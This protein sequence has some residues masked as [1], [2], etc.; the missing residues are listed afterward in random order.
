MSSKMP[1]I[2]QVSFVSVIIQ[3]L[4]LLLMTLGFYQIDKT[5]FLFYSFGVFVVLLVIVRYVIPR[6][7]RQGITLYKMQKFEQ[8]IPFFDK[9][10]QFFK[11]YP[12]IDKYRYFVLLS[13]SRVCYTEMA[14]LNKAFC[15]AQAGKK[16]ESITEYKKVLT[17]FP[18][19]ESAKTALKMLE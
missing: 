11:K 10:Y 13:S 9:S 16:D 17:E 18:D 5:N 8:A 12:W 3:I 6:H 2:K 1:M 4:L 14:L 15:L 19:S 7:H